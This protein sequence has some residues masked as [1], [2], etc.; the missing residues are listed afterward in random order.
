MRL[1]DLRHGTQIRQGKK[2][3]LKQILPSRRPIKPTETKISRRII[4]FYFERQRTLKL[5]QKV[6]TTS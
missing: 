3:F 1:I 2:R 6:K 5:C 4:Q